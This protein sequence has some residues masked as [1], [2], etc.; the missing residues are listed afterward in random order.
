MFFREE[1]ERAEIRIGKK[2]PAFFPEVL[3][4]T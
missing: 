2:N 4:T 3:E 1:N